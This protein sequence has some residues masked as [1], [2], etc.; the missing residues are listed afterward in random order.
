M[1]IYTAF[2]AHNWHL[3]LIA[4]AAAYLLG[5]VNAAVI[6][7]K[8]ATKGKGDIREMGSKNAGFTNV[9]RSVGKLP[10]VFTIAF[11]LLKAIC[12]VLTGGFLFSLMSM[13][14]LS[15]DSVITVGKYVC[16]F[17]CI[18]GHSYP[19]YFGFKG[20]KGV[21]TAAGMM[22]VVDWRVFALILGTFLLIFII[23]KI[24]SLADIICACLFPVYTLCIS[25]V[26]DCIMGDSSVL[27]VVMCT[28]ASFGIGLFVLIKHKENIKRLLKGEEKR[29]SAKK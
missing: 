24:I 23:T 26:F 1:M 25:A 12:A 2:I 28:A 21:V 16:G 29:I 11:D 6:I 5:S 15:P 10:A 20:G 13:G 7:T 4:F 19:L 18:L 27:Y 9:L 17:F 22:I 3:M 8:I 14:E